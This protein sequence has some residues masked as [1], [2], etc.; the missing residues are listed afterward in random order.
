MILAHVI[1]GIMP[2]EKHFS[3]FWFLG[4]I[5]PDLDHIFII[6]KYRFFSLRKIID[7]IFN[8][9]KFGV[10]YKTKYFHSIFGGIIVSILVAIFN[11]SGGIYFFVGYLI[12]LVLD[13]F[14]KDEKEY[15][16]PFKKKI[17]GWLPIF[18]KPEIFFTIF[19][20]LLYLIIK[21]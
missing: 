4:S 8:E 7:S 5:F 15:F 1:I 10:K 6:L 11:F 21:K 17:K 3:W 9:E 2:V 18:S 19:L 20:V 16:F 13:F 12:H 14:D